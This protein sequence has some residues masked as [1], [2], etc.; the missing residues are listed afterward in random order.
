MKTS[1]PEVLTPSEA[2]HQKQI[3]SEVLKIIMS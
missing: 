2:P 1:A 3:S